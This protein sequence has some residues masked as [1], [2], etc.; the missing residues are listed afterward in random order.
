[1]HWVIYDIPSSATQLSEGLSQD[2]ILSEGGTQ[3]LNDFRKIGYGGPY[4]PSGTHRYYFKLYALDT[5]LGLKAGA[6]KDQ[7]LKAMRG[8][9]LGEAQVMGTY[10]R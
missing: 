7:V 2:K 9:I 5:L 1:V 4:P 6:T 8:H 10:R 3:G